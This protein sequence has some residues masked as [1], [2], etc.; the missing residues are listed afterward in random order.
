[1]NEEKE[2]KWLVKQGDFKVSKEVIYYN[3]TIIYEREDK[4]NKLELFGFEKG[5][6]SIQYINPSIEMLQKLNN[7][8]HFLNSN[9][10]Y[11][12]VSKH[13]S[14]LNELKECIDSIISCDPSL[15][16]IKEK[17]YMHMGIH[18]TEDE[19]VSILFQSINRD[20]SSIIKKAKEFQSENYFKP[21]W[22]LACHFESNKEGEKGI[23]SQELLDLY[24]SIS[25]KS[26]Y[27]QEAQ[28]NLFVKHSQ[29]F[30]ETKQDYYSYLE[31][32]LYRA[33]EAREQVFIN[34]TFHALCGY[35][36]LYMGKDIVGSLDTLCVLAKVIREKN[37]EIAELKTKLN[38]L[39]ISNEEKNQ[40]TF[41]N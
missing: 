10:N 30:D 9:A 11:L 1:M 18:K 36:N 26:P 7:S 8:K 17:L 35:K 3:R 24:E 22:E 32:Q 29:L 4:K 15:N 25:K 5:Q 16:L 28:H 31:N 21:I 34:Q 19:V 27:Y 20:S 39:E 14:D 38:L 37:L 33:I 13:I 41:F 40:L 23:S 6:I 2:I 12:L